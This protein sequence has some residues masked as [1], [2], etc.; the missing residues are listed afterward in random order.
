MFFKQVLLKTGSTGLSPSGK[1]QAD[2]EGGSDS[3]P[4]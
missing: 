3:G 4:F 1:E 2:T